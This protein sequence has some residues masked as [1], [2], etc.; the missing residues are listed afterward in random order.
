[1]VSDPAAAMVARAIILLYSCLWLM[2]CMDAYFMMLLCAVRINPTQS[3]HCQFVH[4]TILWT[5]KM[6]LFALVLYNKPGCVPRVQVD[7][8]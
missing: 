1:M 8:V 3:Y 4:N 6:R 7:I 5:Y 2:M